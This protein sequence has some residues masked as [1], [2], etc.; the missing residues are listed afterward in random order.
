MSQTNVLQ[1]LT[2]VA[3]LR[4]YRAKPDNAE[5]AAEIAARLQR[6]VADEFNDVQPFC[7]KN[8][9]RL[10]AGRCGELVDR[11]IESAV[12]LIDDIGP[13]S[14]GESKTVTVSLDLKISRK[15]EYKA[16]I[17]SPNGWNTQAEVS[18]TR[19]KRMIDPVVVTAQRIGQE[20]LLAFNTNHNSNGDQP[21]LPSV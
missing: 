19:P 10:D 21:A 11:E 15:Y 7:A 6:R 4:Q 2:E 14:K 12:R 3:L 1:E 9:H 13:N 18:S 5:L 16:G 20:R 8:L 17:Y